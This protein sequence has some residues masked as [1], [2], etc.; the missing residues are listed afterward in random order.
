MPWTT[1]GGE[2]WGG[3]A[4]EM[5][6]GGAAAVGAKSPISRDRWPTQRAESTSPV[7]VSTAREAKDTA[8]S[9]SG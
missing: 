8:W 7:S 9:T 5:A 3:L 6:D 2:E 4:G 1:S